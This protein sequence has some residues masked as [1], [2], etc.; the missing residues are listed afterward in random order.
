MS[1]KSLERCD[2]T[3]HAYQPLSMLRID[4]CT[5]PSGGVRLRLSGQLTGPWVQELA[6]T[7]RGVPG[8]S[9]TH[10][11]DLK[12]LVFADLEGRRLLRRLRRLGFRLEGLSP[13][14]TAQLGV[15]ETTSED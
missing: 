1:G 12:E 7:C 14:L 4:Q 13:F 10:A 11:L 2:G 8:P 3:N 9:A 5:E 15:E 6:A